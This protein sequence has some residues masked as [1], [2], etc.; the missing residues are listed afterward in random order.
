[1]DYQEF[2]KRKKTEDV[3]T[4]IQKIPELNPMLF[5]FQKDIVRWALKRGRAA[6]FAD[7]GM[8]K[9]GMQLEW[10]NHVPGDVLILAPLAVSSQTVREA[11]K[12]G[13]GEVVYSADG[14]KKGKY[15]ITNY[16]RLEK[17]NPGD[18]TGIV[19]DESSILKSY[20]GKYRTMLV[21]N[22]SSVPFRLAATATPAPND[23]MELGNHAEFLGSMK[24]EEMLAMF[25]VHDGGETQKWRIKGHAR[26][27]FWE[28]VAS[29][30]VMIRK[31]SDLGY[32]DGDFI[33][34]E[35]KIEQITVHSEKATD[36]FLFPMEAQGLGDR[37]KAR[38]TT[39][40]DRCKKAAE[41]VN[42]D[43]EQ[44]IVW[45]DLND[46]SSMLDKMI[47]G[48]VEVAGIHKEDY[49]K[50]KLLGF[51]KDEFRVLT[52]K[53]KIAGWGMN[54]QNCHNMAFVGLSDSY[55]SF[56]QAV[57]RCWRF[58]QKHHV[59]VK[60]ITSDLEGAVVKNI[61][62]K[63]R[64][65]EEMANQMVKFMHKINEKNIRGMEQDKTGYNPQIKMK[66]PEWLKG[67]KE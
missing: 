18:Y 9:T 58:G 13:V 62:R 16:E 35:M 43:N 14:S 12:F 32:E 38:R 36:G 51:A 23:F 41:I 54:Y 44:W 66:L 24:R 53:P 17:F 55:E 56:Y 15:T 29:W 60:V 28:W 19:L 1:M 25:F 21:E 11:E 8:G 57:R 26:D 67:E 6:I 65:A 63:E 10:A 31:P 37:Q 27:D 2:L 42:A 5:D 39:I 45:C 52:S 61:E 64:D 47:N 46:E 33:L 30:A 59:N 50:D 49:K 4:G 20:T 22:W 34:P 40:E 48:S 3:P 7:C